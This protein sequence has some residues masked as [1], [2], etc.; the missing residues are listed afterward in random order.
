MLALGS[1]TL[2]I[3]TFLSE[4]GLRW[5]CRCVAGAFMILAVVNFV[6]ANSEAD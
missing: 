1:A 6:G 2:V 3:S 4:G 5:V